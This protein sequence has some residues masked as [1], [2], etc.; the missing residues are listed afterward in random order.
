[1][2]GDKCEKSPNENY[3]LNLT[4]ICDPNKNENDVAFTDVNTQ[5]GCRLSAKANVRKACPIFSLTYLYGKYPNIFAIVFISCGLLFTF[6]GLKLY[7][8]VLF[9]MTAFI[10]G[11]LVLT[12]VYQMIMVRFANTTVNTFW[13]VLGIAALVGLTVGYFAAS[14][15]KYCFVVAG[16]SLGGIGGFILYTAILSRFLDNVRLDCANFLVVDGVCG[17]DIGSNSLCYN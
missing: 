2:I 11:F 8:I 7:K 15:N 13:F 16:A 12:I 9:L 3:V 10:V 14:Y 17:R 4:L 1:M 5:S 6:F